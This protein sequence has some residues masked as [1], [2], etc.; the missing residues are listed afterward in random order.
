MR[1]GEKHRTPPVSE[2]PADT[3]ALFRGSRSLDERHE[4]RLPEYAITDRYH[5]YGR[6]GARAGRDVPA[7][8][9]LGCVR[10]LEFPLGHLGSGAAYVSGPCTGASVFTSPCHPRRGTGG[11]FDGDG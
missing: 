4:R 2:P 3:G 6:P 1:P 10:F 9:T 5:F 11:G 7:W 8:W